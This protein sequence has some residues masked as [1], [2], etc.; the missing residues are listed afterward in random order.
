MNWFREDQSEV[1]SFD[2]DENTKTEYTIEDVDDWLN[3]M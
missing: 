3:R 2:D 1:I